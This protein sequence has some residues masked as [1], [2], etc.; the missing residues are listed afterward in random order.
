MA[1]RDRE[2]AQ[3]RR[4]LERTYA[5][6]ATLGREK[7]DLFEN[8]M[9]LE[10]RLAFFETKAARAE[11]RLGDELRRTPSTPSTAGPEELSHPGPTHGPGFRS[12]D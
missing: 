4:S 10:Q 12:T 9:S 6:I 1:A 7:E 11:K 8:Q 2:L 3:L 5:E